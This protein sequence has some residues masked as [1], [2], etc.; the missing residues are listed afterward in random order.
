MSSKSSPESQN[1]SK[2]AQEWF[3]MQKD[4]QQSRLDRRAERLREPLSC[5][6]VW[7]RIHGEVTS[8]RLQMYRYRIK[9]CL[10]HALADI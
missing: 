6:L 3:Q 7:V 9:P 10:H 1:E 4:W 2:R 8:C 5:K